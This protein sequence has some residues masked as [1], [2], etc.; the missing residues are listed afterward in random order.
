MLSI[1]CAQSVYGVC[2]SKE[3]KKR[4]SSSYVYT[5]RFYLPELYTSIPP[6]F[7]PNILFLLIVGLL[8][9]LQENSTYLMHPNTIILQPIRLPYL[10][11]RECMIEYIILLQHPSPVVIVI[12]ADLF[13]TVYP[14]VSQCWT[15]TYHDNQYSDEQ[16]NEAAIHRYVC[17]ARGEVGII[18]VH[19]QDKVYSEQCHTQDM[20]TRKK[21][22]EC[23]IFN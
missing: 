1:Q 20:L 7:P 14:I 12:D 17:R 8:P 2:A 19:Q 10:N 16:S 21:F 4:K 6:F 11:T 22:Q 18:V 3:D 15:A 23:I 13:T 5:K 9:V